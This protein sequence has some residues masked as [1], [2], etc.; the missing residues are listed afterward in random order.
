MYF[1]RVAKQLTVYKLVFNS[2]CCYEKYGVDNFK[3]K[4]FV[5]IDMLNLINCSVVK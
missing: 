5:E 3:I 4:K 2:L 1:F